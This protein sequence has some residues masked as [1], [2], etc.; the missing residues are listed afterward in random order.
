MWIDT[1]TGD[2]K[3]YENQPDDPYIKKM[4]WV[5]NEGAWVLFAPPPTPVEFA[6]YMTSTTGN[7]EFIRQAEIM[8]KFARG[9]VDYATMRMNCG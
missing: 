1:R 7:P 5:T 6:N 3:V 8:E 2:I 4:T 9:E